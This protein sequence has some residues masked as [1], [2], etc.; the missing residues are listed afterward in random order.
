MKKP[1]LN[2]KIMSSLWD[3]CMQIGGRMGAR[4]SEVTWEGPY[5][6]R[7]SGKCYFWLCD[8][9]EGAWRGRHRKLGALAGSALP[10]VLPPEK[11]RGMDS[12]QTPGQRAPIFSLTL[13]RTLCK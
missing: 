10:L 8:N 1:N 11:H 5:H 7:T 2:K 12:V 6:I 3:Y 9:Q 4:G 13:A